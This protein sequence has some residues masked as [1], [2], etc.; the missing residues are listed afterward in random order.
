MGAPSLA[1]ATAAVIAGESAAA[2]GDDAEATGGGLLTPPSSGYL[3][4]AL[5]TEASSRLNWCPPRMGG[6]QAGLQGSKYKSI[7]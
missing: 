6:H 4:V 3:H 1:D 2:V 7:N 5:G